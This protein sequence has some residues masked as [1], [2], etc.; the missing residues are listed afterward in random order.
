MARDLDHLDLPQVQAPLARRK[1]GTGRPVER[2]DVAG[3][4]ARLESDALAV[5]NVARR[6]PRPRDI[7]PSLIFRLR[8]HPSANL[9]DLDVDRLGLQILARDENKTLVVFASDEELAEFRRRAATYGSPTGYKYAEM[10]GIDG[11]DPILPI[12]RTGVRLLRDPVTSDDVPVDV[13]LWHPGD[14]AGALERIAELRG[15]VESRDGRMT[16][17][18]IANDLI[19]ARCHVGPRLAA[20][21][22]DLGIVREVDR[23]PKTAIGRLQALGVGA[24]DLPEIREAPDDAA[25]VLILDSGVTANH[26]M[27]AP[28]M[29]EAAVFP[30]ELG[31]RD[32][33]GAADGDQRL[34]GHGTA[35]SGF[36]VWGRPDEAV[37]R[38]SLQ[39]EVALFSARILDENGEYDPDLLVE[40]QLETAVRYFLDTYPQCRVINL[41][42]GDPRVVF[43]DGDRQTRLAARIDQLAYD[44]QMRNVLFVISTGNYNHEPEHHRDHV[45]DYPAYLLGR[46]AG[47]IEPSTAALALTVGGLSDGGHP[48]RLASVAGRRAIAAT[49]E[50]PSPFTR[51]GPGVGG[52]LKP[53]LVEFAG[54]YA[55]D[56]SG[57]VKLDTSDPGLGLPTTNR[58]FAPPE[59]QLL[60][61][62]NGTS[63]AAPAVAH[64]AARLFNRYP[65]ATPNLIRALLADSAQVPEARPAELS[66]SNGDPQV[67]RVYGYGR[68]DFERAANSAENN[69]LLLAEETIAPDAFQL[70]EVPFL[71]VDFLAMKGDRWIS[72]TLAFDPPTRPTRGDSYLGITMQAHLFRNLPRTEVAAAFRDWAAAP[73]GANEDELSMSLSKIRSRYK[74]ELSP[75]INL[76][77]KGTLQRGV[78][79][80]SRSWAYEPETPLVLAVSCLRKWAPEELNSQRYAVIVSLRH[81]HAEARLHT[82]LRARLRPRPRI[83]L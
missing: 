30:A 35:V 24:A 56:P 7:D 68:P 13:E 45:D 4:A 70:F 2:D 39:A 81:S 78:K 25:G 76:R 50:Y 61:A 29:G 69:V 26:P 17:H 34:H 80:I 42:L 63:F 57:A 38:A 74:V 41:S 55:Y 1:H 10:G 40:H 59:G 54:D 72:V 58:S 66:F 73:A 9:T 20:A 32:G 46:P 22:L 18:I 19:V 75:G 62:V 21:L 64:T 53:D 3:H 77:S 31:E 12:D 15:F 79:Q 14:R 11:L 43:S 27:L 49:R 28:A 6:R 52:M 47:L 8:V 23:I 67:H 83:R 33:L 82:P 51:T 5:T 44:L 36:A 65:D 48:A 60:R 16:D 37:K 71:P